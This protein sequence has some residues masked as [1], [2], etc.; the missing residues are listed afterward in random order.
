MS[1][2]MTQT[3]VLAE[4]EYGTV[5]VWLDED[6]IRNDSDYVVISEPVTITFKSLDHDEILQ[7]RIKILDR[8]IEQVRAEAHKKV[9]RLTDQKQRLLAITHED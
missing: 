2:K 1:E 7:S 4:S 5:N 8:E 9:A 3:I 6:Y